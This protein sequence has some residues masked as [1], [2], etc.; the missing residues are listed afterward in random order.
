MCT[1]AGLRIEIWKD[2]LTAEQKR[3]DN[4]KAYQFFFSAMKTEEWFNLIENIIYWAP[5]V[6]KALCAVLPRGAELRKEHF[7]KHV[8]WCGEEWTP[9]LSP[10]LKVALKSAVHTQGI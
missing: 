9:N 6:Y 1:G 4:K 8:F 5:I 2:K 7:F 10:S 3:N